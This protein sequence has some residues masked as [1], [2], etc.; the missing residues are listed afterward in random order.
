MFTTLGAFTKLRKEYV[1]FIGSVCPVLC[2]A[3]HRSVLIFQYQYTKP[4][5]DKL[6]KCT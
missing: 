6:N 3:V 5:A 4:E 1:N 2:L